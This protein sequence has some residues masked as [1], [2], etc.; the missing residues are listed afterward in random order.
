LDAILIRQI[1]RARIQTTL[2]AFAV[3]RVFLCLLSE[4]PFLATINKE[5]ILDNQHSIETESQ[6]TSYPCTDVGNM[7][8]FVAQHGSYLRSGGTA[9]TWHKWDGKR[10]K[11][12]STA[13]IFNLALATVS[14]IKDE[15]HT[16]KASAEV[17]G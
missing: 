17:A 11:P 1:T 9:T 2:P 5:R 14:L 3:W 16:A 7:E 10:W 4:T 6:P 12:S 13:E 8:R 15:V